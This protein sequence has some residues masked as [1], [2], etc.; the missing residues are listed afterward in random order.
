MKDYIGSIIDLTG[1]SYLNPVPAVFDNGVHPRSLG[2]IT[3]IATHHDDTFRPHDYDSVIRYHTEAAQHYTRLGPGLQYHYKI[4]NTGQIFYVRPLTTWLYAV[5]TAENIT[6]LEICLDGNFEPNVP[7]IPEQKPT[8]EQLEAYFQLIKYLC[9]QRPEIPATWPDVRPHSDYSATACCGKNLRDYVYQI[10]D[11][12]TA[13]NFPANDGYDWPEYQ[14]GGAPIPTP[15]SVI[16][17]T[18][19]TP[20]QPV[21][22]P[23][24]P[25]VTPPTPSTPP[26]LVI[27][28]NSSTPPAVGVGWLQGLIAFFQLLLDTLTG[29][30]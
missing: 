21:P 2:Q 20:P 23:Q 5:G 27:P 7:G 17:D 9:T 13:K 8:L 19:P 1:D 12:A 22:L 29:K 16:P 26:P 3:S 6:S 24:P 18:P 14:T 10:K 25:A 30:K 11:E 4:D 28:P 15:P